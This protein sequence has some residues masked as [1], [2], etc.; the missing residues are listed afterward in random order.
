LRWCVRRGPVQMQVWRV[1]KYGRFAA[2]G[3]V[4][5]RA[6]TLRECA[7]LGNSRSAAQREMG[8]AQEDRGR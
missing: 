3:E 6:R 2:G 1:S 4:V 5:G 7:D 8:K